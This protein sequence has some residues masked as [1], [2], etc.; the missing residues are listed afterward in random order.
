M[1]ITKLSVPNIYDKILTTL[2]CRISD[3]IKKKRNY[4][5]NG[6]EIP[7]I[8]R[9]PTLKSRAK[10]KEISDVTF[11]AL[12]FSS[13]DGKAVKEIVLKH[14]SAAKVSDRT[15]TRVKVSLPDASLS[16]C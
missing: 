16:I 6:E 5:R 2:N 15:I 8:G 9:P 4:L 13:R 1:V 3:N 11:N 12:A 10:E 14:S 7:K